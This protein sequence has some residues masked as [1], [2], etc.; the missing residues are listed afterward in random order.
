MKAKKPERP[1]AVEIRPEPNTAGMSVAQV[2]VAA[3]YGPGIGDTSD[4]VIW[5]EYGYRGGTGKHTGYPVR[6]GRVVDYLFRIARVGVFTDRNGW[7]HPMYYGY[8]WTKDGQWSK[9]RYKLY[10]GHV[11]RAMERAAE[12]QAHGLT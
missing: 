11:A 10:P 2:M 8:L 4:D 12:R 1:T 6:T 3:P 9:R 7:R 5:C